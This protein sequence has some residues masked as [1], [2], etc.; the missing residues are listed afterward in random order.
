[1]A[2][3]GPGGSQRQAPGIVRYV[4]E[5]VHSMYGSPQVFRQV[6]GRA[7]TFM[8][9]QFRYHFSQFD[10][11]DRCLSWVLPTREFELKAWA[12]RFSADR[13]S[14]VLEDREGYMHDVQVAARDALSSDTSNLY[15][16]HVGKAG[17]A[18]DGDI[19]DKWT[20]GTSGSHPGRWTRL[21]RPRST[22]RNR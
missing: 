17:Y 14:S 4:Q 8:V 7:A 9:W 21:C 15:G 13:K 16:E 12:R 2:T 19:S 18:E 10:D 3:A 5:G 6:T 1:R 11:Y 20:N 22:G